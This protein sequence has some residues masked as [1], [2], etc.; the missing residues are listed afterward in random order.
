M[1]PYVK[2]T[3]VV[4]P[5]FIYCATDC[6]GH[7]KVGSSSQPEKRLYHLRRTSG[8]DL[9]L[10][11]VWPLGV[12]TRSSGL[13]MERAIHSALGSRGRY[14]EWYQR[15]IDEVIATAND[16]IDYLLPIWQ[17]DGRRRRSA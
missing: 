5:Q 6:D 2:R 3:E 12:W 4:G 7:V 8:R 13:V 14:S 17:A 11:R 10:A 15:P 9:W 1:T 16:V